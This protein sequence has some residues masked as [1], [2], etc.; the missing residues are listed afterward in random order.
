VG[1]I[2][3]RAHIDFLSSWSSYRATSRP[4]STEA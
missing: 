2:V 4:T 3:R 1:A